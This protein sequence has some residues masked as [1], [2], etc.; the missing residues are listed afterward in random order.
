[1]M[2]E[3]TRFFKTVYLEIIIKIHAIELTAAMLTSVLLG[4]I[5]KNLEERAAVLDVESHGTG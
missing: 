1:M 5:D 2:T 3:Y 4:D